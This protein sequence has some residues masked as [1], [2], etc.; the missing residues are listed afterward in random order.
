MPSLSSPVPTCISPGRHHHIPQG[1]M[2]QSPPSSS[3]SVFLCDSSTEP[4]VPL[5]PQSQSLKEFLN[6]VYPFPIPLIQL[7]ST[8]LTNRVVQTSNSASPT[9]TAIPTANVFVATA[10]HGLFSHQ[11]SAVSRPESTKGMRG[12][13]NFGTGRAG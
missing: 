8:T 9:Q 12:G 10:K 5:T 13:G 4:P 6:Q 7:A 2:I 3:L 11:P 1:S